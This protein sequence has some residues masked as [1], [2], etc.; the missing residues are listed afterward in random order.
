[1]PSL[2]DSCSKDRSL[3]HKFYR[4]DIEEKGTSDKDKV[5]CSTS[6][7][8]CTALREGIV[9]RQLV[10]DCYKERDHFMLISLP[11][12]GLFVF[13]F[14]MRSKVLDNITNFVSN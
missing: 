5:K 1:M 7:T 4:K 6:A 2:R 11:K 12:I 3:N 9:Y 14:Q 10:K 8:Q 13:M